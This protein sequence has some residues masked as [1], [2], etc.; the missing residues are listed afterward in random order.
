[1]TFTAASMFSTAVLE[2]AQRNIRIRRGSDG[3]TELAASP[4][5]QVRSIPCLVCCEYSFL[6]GHVLWRKDVFDDGA[7]CDVLRNLQTTFTQRYGGWFDGVRSNR[8]LKA[9]RCTGTRDL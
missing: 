3:F 5:L 2:E 8:R 6:L 7:R 1:M 9:S 4:T